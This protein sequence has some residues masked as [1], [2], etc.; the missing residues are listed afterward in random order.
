MNFFGK[1]YS[2]FDFKL[3]IIKKEGIKK[4]IEIIDTLP[5][6]EKLSA[7]IKKN[8]SGKTI[9]ITSTNEEVLERAI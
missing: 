4:Q 8:K 2:S 3:I 1:L 6:T 9:N 5:N 7:K